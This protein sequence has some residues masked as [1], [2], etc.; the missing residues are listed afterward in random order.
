MPPKPAAA[1]PKAPA[2]AKPVGAKQP[3]APAAAAKKP[4]ASAG[5]AAAASGVKKAAAGAGAKKD[6]KQPLRGKAMGAVPPKAEESPKESAALAKHKETFAKYDEEK[7][8]ALGLRQLARLIK[9]VLEE[10]C[11]FCTDD[12]VGPYIKRAMEEGDKD[13][14]KKL[15]IAEFVPWHSQFRAFIEQTLGD[16]KNTKAAEAQAA[17]AAVKGL[18]ENMDKGVIGECTMPQLPSAIDHAI[19]RGKTPLLI[20]ATVGVEGE[21]FSPLE[22]F[23]SYRS[24]ALV[25]MKKMVVD[26]N[27]TKEKTLEEALEGCKK[28]LVDAIKHGKSLMI[29]M[30]NS[31]PPLTTKFTSPTTLPIDVL[32]A[33]K[34]KAVLSKDYREWEGTFLPLIIDAEKDKCPMVHKDFKVVLVTKFCAED[35]A[36][37]L[38]DEIPLG[39]MQPIKVVNKLSD[40]AAY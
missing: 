5:G 30:S 3:A 27:M 4:A 22:T 13:K 28:K 36:E 15:N 2:A 18:L 12:Q 6:D 19:S 10:E 7:E 24:E 1:T 31:A 21:D 11:Q 20:D 9:D 33:T 8:G 26:V 37:F 32:D 17:A 14:D 40:L 38:G 23:Y 34:V 35:Y 16:D 29:M 25:E 39:L